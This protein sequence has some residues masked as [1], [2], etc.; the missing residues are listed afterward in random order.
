MKYILWVLHHFLFS[1]P[2]LTPAQPQQQGLDGQHTLARGGQHGDGAVQG[3]KQ[4]PGLVQG[5]GEHYHG[6]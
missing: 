1:H 5:W 2:C 3:Q 4:H 6:L